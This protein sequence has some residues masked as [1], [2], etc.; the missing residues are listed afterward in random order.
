MGLRIKASLEP[1]DLPG[2]GLIEMRMQ[3]SEETLFTMGPQHLAETFALYFGSAFRDHYYKLC[4]E[5]G[6]EP[7]RDWSLGPRA[8]PPAH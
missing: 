3:V 8:E 1:V 4:S 7:K 2:A 5:R 6:I